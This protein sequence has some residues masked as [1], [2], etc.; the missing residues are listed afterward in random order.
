MQGLEKTISG[1]G[2]FVGFWALLV[3]Q[4]FFYLNKQLGSWLVD[5]F[6]A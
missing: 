5:Y 2:G 4:F 1:G 3:F 6:Q